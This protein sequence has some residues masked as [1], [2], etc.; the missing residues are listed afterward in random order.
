MPDYTLL[1]VPKGTVLEAAVKTEI[2]FDIEK[3]AHMPGVQI[4]K[5]LLGRVEWDCYALPSDE[6]VHDELDPVPT[7]PWSVML[8]Q[9]NNGYVG[10][11]TFVYCRV[12]KA[13][14]EGGVVFAGTEYGD[15]LLQT[16]ADF[17]VEDLAL[18]SILACTRLVAEIK[19]GAPSVSE[20]TA[21]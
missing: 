9:Y 11:D 4:A 2:G 1:V 18:E 21:R 16:G 3:E 14:K 8:W 19:T 5:D 7:A 6:W 12:R 17:M 10:D 20:A 13:G 15:V